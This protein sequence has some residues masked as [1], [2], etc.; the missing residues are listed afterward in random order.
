[1]AEPS[2]H[3]SHPC[4]TVDPIHA[5]AFGVIE[6][7]HRDDQIAQTQ[8]ATSK[9]DAEALAAQLQQMHDLRGCKARGD[10]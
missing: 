4:V 5:T 8:I 2:N 9:E 10:Q 3:P 1:M 6:D 7:L